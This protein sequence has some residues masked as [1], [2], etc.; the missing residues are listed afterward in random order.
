MIAPK[1]DGLEVLERVKSDPGIRH[2]AIVMLNLHPR[3][4]GI[5]CAAMRLSQCF[6]I[7]P[8]EFMELNAAQDLGVYWAILNEPSPRPERP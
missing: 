5:W 6:L 2:I 7:K 3:G 1:S 8:M 4:V